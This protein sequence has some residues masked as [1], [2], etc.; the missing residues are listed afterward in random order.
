LKCENVVDKHDIA[1]IVDI[2]NGYG[3]TDGWHLKTDGQTDPK[4]DIY[5]FGVTLWE[6]LHDGE[7]PQ[8]GGLVQDGSGTD[9]TSRI[10]RCC[11]CQNLSERPSL[12]TVF[13]ELGGR[14]KFGCKSRVSGKLR[15]IWERFFKQF[16][17]K[18][19]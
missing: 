16:L 1:Q 17:S 3:H 6:I 12:T 15:A 10:I 9:A 7:D 18:I 8:T 14:R 4:R 19:G 2:S 5:S 11:A 13:C